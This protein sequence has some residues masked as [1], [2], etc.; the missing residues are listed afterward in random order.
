MTPLR[1]V[2]LWREVVTGD[3]T[4]LQC[5]RLDTVCGDFTHEERGLGCDCHLKPQ[6]HQLHKAVWEPCATRSINHEKRKVHRASSQT[7]ATNG[8][9][10][11][12]PA[13]GITHMKTTSKATRMS[14]YRRSRWCKT[15]KKVTETPATN[16]V[17][18][19]N[20]D[21]A[22]AAAEDL[23]VARVNIRQERHMVWKL[24]LRM[25]EQCRRDA[26]VAY[27]LAAIDGT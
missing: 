24:C 20:E 8:R 22:A 12:P 13:S 27:D 3:F 7:T 9:K 14:H 17:L 19:S 26:T 10:S 4:F 2:P 25:S 15:L 23:N 11:A 6:P 1:S 21:T 5:G 16:E 18:T